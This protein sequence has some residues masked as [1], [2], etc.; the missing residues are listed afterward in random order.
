MSSR[1]ILPY[2]PFLWCIHWVSVKIHYSI[3][4]Q[5]IRVCI[6]RWARMKSKGYVATEAVIPANAPAQSLC[7]KQ[8]RVNSKKIKKKTK[9][10]NAEELNNLSTGDNSRLP[11]NNW[12]GLKSVCS[13]NRVG[14]CA[15]PV[16]TFHKQRIVSRMLERSAIHSRLLRI[17]LI[18]S[19]PLRNIV[20]KNKLANQRRTIPLEIAL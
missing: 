9:Q 17:R 15:I 13:T 2:T 11:Y 8:E 19:E 20:W 10:E 1:D 12:I 6:D 14:R 5:S 16:C 18:M 4:P 3:Q 7:T